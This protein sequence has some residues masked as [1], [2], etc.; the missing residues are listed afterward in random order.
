MNI[1]DIFDEVA[2]KMRS[3]LEMAR[4]A[5]TQPGLRGASF[6]E[7]LR[8][9]LVKYLPQSLDISSGVLVDTSGRISRQIDVIISDKAN[10]P[11]F[12]ESGDMRVIPVECVY[13]VIEVKAFVDLDELKT[14]FQN[15]LSIRN[16]KKTAYFKRSSPILEYEKLYGQEWDI[17]PINYYVFA[18]DSIELM[19]LAQHINEKHKAE[20]FPEFS[21]I[22]TVC[23]LDKG[24]ICNQ[25][26]DGKIDPLPQP[27][28]T[29][30]VCNTSRS[31]L[32][33]YT[34]ISVY[35]NQARLPNFRFTDYLGNLQF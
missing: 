25:S 24:V 14:I 21:R 15:M 17:W 33:F 6:E 29:L 18:Y 9:F 2:K 27:G 23:V 3:D 35:L 5:V 1:A 26:A 10:T 11:I 31:L 4:I 20:R 8:T 19:T 28:S 34:L 7:I 32:L 13:A 22:D 30:H 12:Y 16:L